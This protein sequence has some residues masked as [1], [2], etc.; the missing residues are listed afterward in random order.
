VVVVSVS[1]FLATA[2]TTY[3]RMNEDR[4]LSDLQD[5]CQ[6]LCRSFRG[7]DAVLEKEPFSKEPRTGVF[8]AAR[9]DGLATGEI[10]K[11]LN[12]Q[13]SYNLTVRDLFS[14]QNWSFGRPVPALAAMKA[15]IASAA[16]VADANGRH[17]PARIEVVMWE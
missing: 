11:E 15:S 3:G 12:S 9:L 8:A 13:H 17:D 4:E 5:G 6:R 1:M 2:Y 16:V 7:Y 14:G 10:E